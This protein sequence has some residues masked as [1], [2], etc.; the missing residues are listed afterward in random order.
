MKVRH[1]VVC[2]WECVCVHASDPTGVT[3]TPNNRPSMKE[4]WPISHQHTS[5]LTCDL[6]KVGQTCAR[7]HVQWGMQQYMCGG[8]SKDRSLCLYVAANRRGTVLLGF[9]GRKWLII[10]RQIPTLCESLP[11]S[12]LFPNST[13]SQRYQMLYFLKG[14][15]EPG[16]RRD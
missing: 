11:S 15:L 9:T 13:R 14:T 5:G 4:S 16:F 2:I 1:L 12:H 10:L 8:L 7:V 3:V 6:H